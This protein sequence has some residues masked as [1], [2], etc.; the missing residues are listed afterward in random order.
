M[1][2]VT[3]RLEEDIDY[4]PGADT[5]DINADVTTDEGLSTVFLRSRN[6]FVAENAGKAVIHVVRQKHLQSECSVKYETQSNPSGA[7]AGK[8]FIETTGT[9]RSGQW[10]CH[11]S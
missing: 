6:F 11:R 7:I 5:S 10:V 8:D 3:E 2:A 1:E 9:V 4:D